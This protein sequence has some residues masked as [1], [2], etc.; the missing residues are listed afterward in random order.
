MN[1][2]DKDYY[3]SRSIKWVK[4]LDNK[5]RFFKAVLYRSFSN[6]EVNVITNQTLRNF[7]EML[8]RIPYVGG[9]KNPLT[10]ALIVS[11]W[12]AALHIALKK[13]EANDNE[14][15]EITRAIATEI[16]TYEMKV[17]QKRI[18]LTPS[19]LRPIVALRPFFQTFGTVAFTKKNFKENYLITYVSG[20]RAEFDWLDNPE[21]H[22]VVRLPNNQATDQVT[23][24]TYRINFHKNGFS[25]IELLRSDVAVTA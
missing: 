20:A 3:V 12:F 17:R 5:M 14:I 23:R 4:E 8:P 10:D 21:K 7:M 9:D 16:A 22:T 25:G 1:Q 2:T 6:A 19:M 15:G 13:Q 11:S 24:Y 18:A